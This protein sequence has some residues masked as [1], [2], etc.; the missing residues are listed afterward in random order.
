MKTKLQQKIEAL[1]EEKNTLLEKVGKLK[2]VAELSEKAEELEDEVNRLKD[3]VKTLKD[4]IPQEFLQ[5]LEEVTSARSSQ[6]NE[7]D[8]E[9]SSCEE[10]DIL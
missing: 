6:E 9:C 5:E 7:L 10:E 2:D 1:E 4:K 3:E 8:K